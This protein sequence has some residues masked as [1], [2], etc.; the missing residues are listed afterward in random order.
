[1]ADVLTALTGGGSDDLYEEIIR[2]NLEKRVLVFNDDVNE[3]VLENYI[4]Y[5]LKWNREDKEAGIP[6]DKRKKITLIINSG[7]GDAFSGFNFVDVV[8]ESITP[9]RAICMSM[10]CSMAYHLFICCKERFAFPNSV[11]LQ[12]DGEL[13][14]QNSTSKVRD[15][16]RFFEDMERRTKEH[17]LKYTKMTE[18]F[19]DSHYDQEYW[20]YAND[21]GKELGCVDYIIGEDCTLDDIL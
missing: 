14:L 19:Y 2:E 17:V 7:G 1:M 15:T 13:T 4:L 12:H 9:I 16:M 10:A 5:I 18:E 8:T 21:K 6:A 20:M 3:A 11:L